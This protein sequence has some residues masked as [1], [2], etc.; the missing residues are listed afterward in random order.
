[1]I[2]MNN[3]NSQYN[4]TESSIRNMEMNKSNS[5]RNIESESSSSSRGSMFLNK[6]VLPPLAQQLTELSCLM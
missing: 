5:S 3:T 4:S 6:V 2:I 1:L